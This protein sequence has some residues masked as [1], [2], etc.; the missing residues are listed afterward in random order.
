MYELLY[1]NDIVCTLYTACSGVV[2]GNSIVI[3]CI[4]SPPWPPRVQVT[5]ISTAKHACT[6]E[7]GAYLIATRER[8]FVPYYMAYVHTYVHIR[9]SGDV[10]TSLVWL[11]YTSPTHISTYDIIVEAHIYDKEFKTAIF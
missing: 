10:C 4:V 7:G 3:C 6:P 11:M 9:V 2:C 5:H 8:M 1:W